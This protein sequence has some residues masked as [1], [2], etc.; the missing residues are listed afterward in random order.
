MNFDNA[1]DYDARFEVSDAVGIGT[2]GVTLIATGG[3]TCTGNVTAYSDRRLKSNL[4]T[5]E[6]ALDK[7]EIICG[8][9]Y[10]KDGV[11]DAGLIAQDVQVV[12]PEAVV[13]RG[14]Y[15]ALNQAAVMGLVVNSINEL[16]EQ[17]RGLTN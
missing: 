13:E 16:R 15:L 1:L 17:V 5:I 14:G 3:F 9:T 12:L 10:D 7:L 2:G 4:Q 11:R 8:F 6:G